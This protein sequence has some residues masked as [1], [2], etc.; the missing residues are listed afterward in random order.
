MGSAG[1]SEDSITPTTAAV[2]IVSDTKFAAAAALYY[3][4]YTVFNLPAHSDTSNYEDIVV[5]KV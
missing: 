3:N 4:R 5:Q 2:A 1:N